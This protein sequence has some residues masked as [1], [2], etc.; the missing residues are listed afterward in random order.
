MG[1]REEWGGGMDGEEGG[2][3]RGEGWEE[4]GWGGG[5]DGEEG[6]MDSREGWEEGGNGKRRWKGGREEGGI[7][8]TFTLSTLHTH[9]G[10]V[11]SFPQICTLYQI[12][13]LL[14][15]DGVQ[16]FDTCT[17]SHMHTQCKCKCF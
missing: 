4:E 2:M 8:H 12:I 5:R 1:R 11:A 3:E 7:P 17:H 9:T 15:S 16:C 14:K 13:V 10:I 6:R